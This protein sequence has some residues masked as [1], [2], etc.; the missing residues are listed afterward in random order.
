MLELLMSVAYDA[1]SAAFDT[2]GGLLLQG[3]SVQQHLR[4]QNVVGFLLQEFG[5]A[6][7]VQVTDASTES[8]GAVSAPGTQQQPVPLALLMEIHGPPSRLTKSLDLKAAPALQ[9][10][11]SH[12]PKIAAQHPDSVL[13]SSRRMNR[14]TSSLK[15]AHSSGIDSV[16]SQTTSAIKFP[17][18]FIASG[19]LEEDLDR[20]MELDSQVSCPSTIKCNNTSH[21]HQQ[22]ATPGVCLHD[23]SIKC[24]AYN[25]MQHEVRARTYS[26]H[27]Q[28]P[29]HTWA[30][31]CTVLLLCKCPH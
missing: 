1:S 19:D 4:E 13:V 3:S 16:D 23:V 14:A 27:E 7:D 9:A 21:K 30:C 15:P 28:I 17:P 29:L 8:T 22:A 6:V 20:L 26:K 18:G 24:Y 11:S 5:R 25:A 2:T 10:Q 31:L 12:S